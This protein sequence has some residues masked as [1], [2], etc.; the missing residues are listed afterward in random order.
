MV[1]PRVVDELERIVVWYMTT[2]QGRWE[3]LT[4]RPFYADPSRVGR[5]AVDLDAIAARDP[6]AMFQLLVTLAAYHSRR[7]VDIMA[8]QRSTPARQAAAM[9]S[10]SRSVSCV[11]DI[12]FTGILSHSEL[13][14]T[15]TRSRSW[16][17]AASARD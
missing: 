2:V 14:N 8:I 17:V 5:F 13:W 9:T 15:G 16:A 6:D 12:I 11:G 3:G 1:A 10:P 7:D 4:V